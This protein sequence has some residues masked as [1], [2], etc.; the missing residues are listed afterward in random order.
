MSVG[1]LPFGFDNICTGIVQDPYVQN[2][3]STYEKEG[4]TKF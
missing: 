4:T 3:S 1:A 2:A